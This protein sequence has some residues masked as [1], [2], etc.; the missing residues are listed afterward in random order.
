L[1]E[2]FPAIARLRSNSGKVAAPRPVNPARK[3]VRRE[4]PPQ[5]C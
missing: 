2:A 5:L 3:I 1:R 4:T